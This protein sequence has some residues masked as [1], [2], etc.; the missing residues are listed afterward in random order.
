MVTTTRPPSPTRRPLPAGRPRPRPRRPRRGHQPAG[1]ILTTLLVAFVVAAL[2]N[3]DAMVERAERKPL[4]PGR[5]RSLAIWHPVQD[6]SH[7]LQ[8]YRLRDLGDALTGND[9]S[10]PSRTPTTTPDDSASGGTT[11]VPPRPELRTPTAAAPLRLWVGGDS[12]VRDFGES[13]LR[14]AADDPLV[15]PTMHYEI[16]TGLTRPDYYDWP[17]ALAQDMADTD[18]EVVLIM[19]GAND[20]QG[21]IAADGTTYQHVS[22]AGWQR[23]Y[24]IRVA[25]VMD[26]LQAD[27]R[28]VFWIAQPPMRDGD[29]DARMDIVNRIY[30]EEASTRPWVEF[31]ETEP[32]FG[33]DNGNYAD[34]LPGPD[35]S[36]EDLRQDDGIHLSREGADLLAGVVLGLVADEIG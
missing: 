20:G 32:F 25:A 14:L 29:F 17:A 6:I 31:V 10:P 36:L 30:R 35:G 28:L 8:L 19:F 16:S 24:G 2:V 26:Q 34:F 12:M 4:G 13:V 5:D 3:A 1:Q 15:A 18:A 27:D 11:T 9:D 33:D 7:I 21:L 23:E 22:D